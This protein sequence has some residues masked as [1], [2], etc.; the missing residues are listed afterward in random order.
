MAPYQ[1]RSGGYEPGLL[2]YRPTLHRQHGH[3]LGSFLGMVVRKLIP[4]AKTYV[5]PHAMNGL[6]NVAKDIWDGK[7]IKSS[8]KDNAK[9]VF[10][11]VANQIMNQTGSGIRR[12]RK[13]KS[14]SKTS[15]SSKRRK[16][17][18]KKAKKAKKYTSNKRRK[19]RKS[20]FVTLFD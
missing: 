13:R 2:V 1:E 8:I 4:L 10:K 15:S 9:G 20:D 16:T 5:L 7:E 12:G 14:S 6:K 11:G 3:G 17:H 18:F 19:V